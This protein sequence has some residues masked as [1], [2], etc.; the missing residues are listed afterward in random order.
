MDI[1]EQAASILKDLLSN[2]GIVGEVV[3][4]K[5]DDTTVL[6]IDSTERGMLIGYHGENLEALQSILRTILYRQTSTWYPVVVDTGG[7]RA[8][9]VQK[10]QEMASRSADKARFFNK[11]IALPPMSSSDRREI[12]LILAQR[13]D[14]VSES[15]GD[16]SNRHVVVKPVTASA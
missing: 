10:L 2:L 1:S 12:H 8:E 7:Y 9:R 14:V 16:A 3:V 11:E 4:S 13:E 15:V 6:T 5:T